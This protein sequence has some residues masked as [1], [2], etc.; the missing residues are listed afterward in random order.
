MRDDADVVNA[1]FL[2][3]AT[4]FVCGCVGVVVVTGKVENTVEFGNEL[5]GPDL[6][7]RLFSVRR[8]FVRT[9]SNG[10]HWRRLHDR[11]RDGLF[12]PFGRRVRF[13]VDHN[14]VGHAGLIARETL[15]RRLSIV[16]RPRIEAWDLAGRTLSWAETE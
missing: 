13:I 1:T 5:V 14:D 4:E 12:H 15:E 9:Q 6:G 16:F 10:A 11:Y 8:V 2:E 7:N 3:K